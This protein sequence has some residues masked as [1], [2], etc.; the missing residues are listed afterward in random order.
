[1]DDR[2]KPRHSQGGMLHVIA[3]HQSRPSDDP[4]FALNREATQRKE[5]GEAIV[6]AT[7][8]ALL[9]DAGKLAVLP[10]SARVVHDVPSAE[11]AAYAPI[12][13]MPAFLQAVIEDLLGKEP[14]L[15]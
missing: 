2:R 12:A 13:G 7:V 10:T 3:S 15:R 4:I 9:D 14:S 8:G 6:N 1:M 11:W 5:K